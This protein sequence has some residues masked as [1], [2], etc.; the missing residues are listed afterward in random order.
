MSTIDGSI[1]VGGTHRSS[2]TKFRAVNPATGAEL[3]L[4]FC[5]ASAADVDVA[6]TLAAACA[7]SFASLSPDARAAFIEAVAQ[8]ILAIGDVLIET[9]M[10]E[11]GLPRARLEGEQ[12]R[13]VNQLRLFA[14]EVRDGAWLD[15]TIDPAMPDRSPPRGDLRRMNHALGPVAVFGA[16]NFPLAFSVAGATQRRLLPPA[17]P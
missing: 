11:T 13:T 5:E 6:C 17:A 12:M 8:A 2:P 15:V 9:A 7:E 4:A 16:S 3:P 14:G 1:F 10:A